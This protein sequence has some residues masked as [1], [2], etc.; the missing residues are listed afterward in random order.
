M[1]GVLRKFLMSSVIVGI[2]TTLSVG[3]LIHQETF[4][5]DGDGTRYEL[6]DRGHEDTN[7]PDQAS[8]WGIWGHNFD[9][10][11]AE[12]GIPATAP[13]KRAGILWNHEDPLAEFGDLATE[14]S[15]NIWVSLVK[16]ATDNKE[17]AKIG[18]F[19][20]TFSTGAELVADRLSA[21]GYE[22]DEIFLPEDAT[23]EFDLMIHSSETGSPSFLETPIPIISF[24]GG[25]HDDIGLTG[26]GAAVDFFDAVTIDIPAAA[27]GHPALGGATGSIPWTTDAAQLQTLGK[28]HNG[29]T[30]LA[31]VAYEDPV[32]G[33]EIESSALY[34]IEEGAPLLG[35]FNP[36]PE[37]DGYI[38]GAA[39][40]KFGEGGEKALTLNPIDISGQDD[41]RMSVMLAATAADFENGDYLRIEAIVD[42]NTSLVEEFYGVNA[43]GT[44]CHKGLSN[45]DAIDGEVGDICIPTEAFGDYEW[46]LPSGSDLELRFS[47]LTTWGNELVAIDNIRVYS[48]DLPPV[49]P[50]GDFSGNGE[51]GPEDLD[52]LAQAMISGENDATY[53]LN[54]DGAV[55]VAD[56]NQW[57]DLTN[58]YMGDSNFDG[59]FSSSDFVTVFGAAKYETGE[60]ATWAEGDWNGD[61]AFNSSDFVAAFSGGG[62]E[63]GPRDGGLQVVP[64][65]SSVVLLV[66]LAGLLTLRRRR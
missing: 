65:P 66:G 60:A 37:G 35:A 57:L 46:K 11:S 63:K 43:A 10:P 30:S 41:V 52:L 51:R 56:R 42:G 48:G 23:T 32:T 36:D 33:D 26:I 29:G 1:S 15:L 18:V 25:D 44:D 8:G 17:G 58:T 64:E 19:P 45:N 13:A 50:T 6:F 31:N 7:L 39:L 2:T 47:T 21:E 16:W 5:T 55:D 12:I 20:S 53:D 61:G 14:E 62:Y 22:V 3:Q 9:A 27:E 40:N 28:L 54:E 34:V 4:E 38:I 24:S 49:G 59:E